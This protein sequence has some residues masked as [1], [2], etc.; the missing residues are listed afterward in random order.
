LPERK[1]S[2][3]IVTKSGNFQNE[4]EQDE[5]IAWLVTKADEFTKVFKKLL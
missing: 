2:R 4:S 1:A 5:L 3:V